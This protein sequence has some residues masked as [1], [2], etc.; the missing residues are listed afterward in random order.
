MKLNF[1]LLLLAIIIQ[2][3][4][5]IIFGQTIF[6]QSIFHGGITSEGFTTTLRSGSGLFNVSL[7]PNSTIKKL[8][9]FVDNMEMQNNW[10]LCKVG[11]L[12]T[13]ILKTSRFFQKSCIASVLLAFKKNFKIFNSIKVIFFLKTIEIYWNF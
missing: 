9:Y 1:Y 6:Y 2:S 4:L 5:V 11:Q 3:Q 13:S 10:F 7:N 8:F 12:S